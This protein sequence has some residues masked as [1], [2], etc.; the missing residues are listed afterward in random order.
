[1]FSYCESIVPTPSQAP[2][3]GLCLPLYL[4]SA[5]LTLVF[6]FLKMVLLLLLLDRLWTTFYSASVLTWIDSIYIVS[7]FFS[8]VLLFFLL[9]A[10]SVIRCWNTGWDSEKFSRHWLRI[11]GGFRSCMLFFLS[12]FLNLRL[13][14]T[15]SL[16]FFGGMSIHLSTA[17]LAHLFSYNM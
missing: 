2:N 9:L 16:F 1:M 7:R 4:S 12:G 11:W 14:W 13:N 8:L 15:C 6:F 3:L 17:M 5:L 10:I